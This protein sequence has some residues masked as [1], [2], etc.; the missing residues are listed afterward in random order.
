MLQHF[1]ISL[2]LILFTV[3]NIK[4]SSAEDSMSLEASIPHIYEFTSG[5]M[6]SVSVHIYSE[7]DIWIVEQFVIDSDNLPTPT[8][9][10]SFI[11]SEK[12]YNYAVTNLGISESYKNSFALDKDPQSD[13]LFSENLS[14]N[15]ILW[16]AE[17]EWTWDW[18]ILFA[19]W[20]R[21]NLHPLFFQELGIEN[22]CAD[23]YYQAR[24][25]FAYENKLPVS[26]R[27]A[28]GDS[29]F[30][31]R[32]LRSEWKKLKYDKDWR[33]NKRFL[34]AL[35]YI[36]GTTY[37]HTLA[38]DT[39]PVEVTPQGLIEGTAY[40][41]LSGNS[42]H[43][44]LVNEINLGDNKEFANRLPMYT[45]NSTVPKTIRP[46][47]E[48]MFSESTLPTPTSKGHTGFVRF[49]W[50]RSTTSTTLIDAQKMPFYSLEQYNPDLLIGENGEDLSFAIF[51][52][53][54]LNPHFDPTLRVTEGLI[55]IASL[56]EARKEVVDQG[57]IACK[58]N[59]ADGT[60][61]YENWSTPSRDRRL[62]NYILDLENYQR[63]L[64]TFP[65]VARAWNEALSQPIVTIDN[66]TYTLEHVKWTFEND[67]FDSNPNVHPDVRWGLSPNAFGLR[68]QNSL[69]HLIAQREISAN[70]FEKCAASQDCFLFSEEFMSLSSFESD[71]AL[72]EQLTTLQSYCPLV[73]AEICELF[74]QKLATLSTPVSDHQNMLETWGKINLLNSA[75]NVPLSE[76]WGHL[77]SAKTPLMLAGAYSIIGR[78]NEFFYVLEKKQSHDSELILLNTQTRNIEWTYKLPSKYSLAF[79]TD[80][81]EVIILD[82]KNKNINLY[83]F[84]SQRTASLNVSELQE[85][86]PNIN[87]FNIVIT[88]K[89]HFYIKAYDSLWT[90]SKKE[91]A[92]QLAKTM[93]HFEPLRSS[94]FAVKTSGPNLGV[95]SETL[96]ITISNMY[97]PSENKTVDLT[98][99][100]SPSIPAYAHFEL[101]TATHAT[102]VWSEAYNESTYKSGVIRIDLISGSLSVESQFNTAPTQIQPRVIYQAQ[103]AHAKGQPTITFVNDAFE[104]VKTLVLE[105]PCMNCG[106]SESLYYQMGSTLYYLDIPNQKLIAFLKWD[107]SQKYTYVDKYNHFLIFQTEI[108]ESSYSLLIDANTQKI[109][110]SND[111]LQFDQTVNTVPLVKGSKYFSRKNSETEYDIS[112]HQFHVVFDLLDLSAPLATTAPYYPESEEGE[113]E[114]YEGGYEGEE[115]PTPARETLETSQVVYPLVPDQKSINKV[116]ELVSIEILAPE[117]LKNGNVEAPIS[118][119]NFGDQSTVILFR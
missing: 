59:C 60:A 54:R 111:Q 119:L 35:D 58:N 1:L 85:I 50:P 4:S 48:S 78:V 116:G 96:Q 20:M 114:G 30:T 44:L 82:L 49:R 27:L 112:Y 95:H 92:Y 65:E 61:D 101:N 70:A 72:R 32:T 73:S 113:G 104:I 13:L 93:A 37:T 17:N 67:F 88:K 62:K 28:S 51:V 31:H 52:F 25:I 46:L 97:E 69:T 68:T 74:Y 10:W 3:F 63:N 79:D 21:E 80:N 2:P 84:L 26:F 102:I 14:S 109:L 106:Y 16:K 91:G 103:D 18:E 81:S 36:A 42:G 56:L 87:Y 45:L 117:L 11:T 38:R 100:L 118:I 55:E 33:K 43:T 9:R 7:D 94:D 108:E 75:P 8:G 98:Q 12:A 89:D 76:R 34:K 15:D 90:F 39:Y 22:D 41:T 107:E 86:D 5:P 19:K 71:A 57:Y 23:A 29:Y 99:F 105:N 83:N 6:G 66:A 64:H 24:M 115:T 77:H 40:L 47:F 53:K 110:L